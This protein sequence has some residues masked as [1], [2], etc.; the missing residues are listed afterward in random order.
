MS[1]ETN[2]KAVGVNDPVNPVELT[3]GEHLDFQIKCARQR[4]EEL[5]V[6]KA[7]AEAVQIPDF[8]MSFMAKISGYPF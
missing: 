6:T 2:T 3:V 8:P 4:V 5:C 7:R 1:A